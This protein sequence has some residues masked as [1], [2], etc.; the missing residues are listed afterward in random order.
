M[1]PKTVAEA[2]QKPRDMKLV[3]RYEV[4]KHSQK[5]VDGLIFRAQ[6]GQKNSPG[7]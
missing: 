5:R 3:S 7:R 4:W 1:H 6:T 2:E